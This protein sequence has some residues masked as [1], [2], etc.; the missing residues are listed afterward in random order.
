[1]SLAVVKTAQ[2]DRLATAQANVAD[3]HDQLAAINERRRLVEQGAAP[4]EAAAG[5]AQTLRQQ[6]STAIARML[7]AG[8]VDR[9]AP[10]L[11]AIDR[12]LAP[13][14]VSEREAVAVLQTKAILLAELDA[15]ATTLASQL[16]AARVE[17]LQAQHGAAR[18]EIERELLPSY[19]R[20]C[21][22]QASAYA[23]LAGA[24]QA[25]CE[26]ARELRDQHGITSPPLG[27]DYPQGRLIFVAVGFG[28]DHGDGF[29]TIG[30]DTS[31]AIAQEAQ[32]AR[33]RWLA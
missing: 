28:L 27:V 18:S 22:A 20:T 6:L 30:I 23:R 14:E 1:M 13:A 2:E 29:N 31:A 3:L 12:A 5:T 33:E 10:E 4:V 26:I 15:E 24:G 19:R 9:G 8:K 25:H 7:K 32:L 16:Q 21:E 17:L 11:R